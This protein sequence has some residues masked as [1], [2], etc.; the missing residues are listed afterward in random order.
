VSHAHPAASTTWDGDLR[1]VRAECP[2]WL[3]MPAIEA[4]SP[5]GAPRHRCRRWKVR[6]TSACAV[7]H[8]PPLFTE[9]G[10]NLHTPA[11][12]G[13]DDFQANRQADKRYRIAPLKGLWTH[14]KGG[15]YHDGRFATLRDVVNHY[16][17]VLGLGLNDREANELVEYLKSL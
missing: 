7:C 4:E 9:P 2:G 16:H 5:N 12:I 14:Q 3:A 13:I 17:G 15:F 8:V 10:W 1:D 6:F 11:E